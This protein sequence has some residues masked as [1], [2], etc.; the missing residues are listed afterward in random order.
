MKERTVGSVGEGGVRM[1]LGKMVYGIKKGKP[2]SKNC[3][4][5]LVKWKSFSV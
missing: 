4:G 2:F 5:I 1:S 3:K